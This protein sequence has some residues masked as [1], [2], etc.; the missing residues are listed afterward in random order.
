MLGVSAAQLHDRRT[1]PL[2]K[3]T[4]VAFRLGESHLTRQPR[5]RLAAR[6]SAVFPDRVK[7]GVRL[8]LRPAKGRIGQTPQR[9]PGSRVTADMGV[10]RIATVERALKQVRTMR[11][12]IPSGDPLRPPTAVGA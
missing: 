12:E 11:V 9:F 10:A 2:V 4:D 3:I 6:H 5:I 8:G 1:L 7:R